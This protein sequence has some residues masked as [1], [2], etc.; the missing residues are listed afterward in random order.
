MRHSML[1]AAALAAVTLLPSCIFGC[2]AYSGDG[3]RAYQRGS[4]SM[5]ICTNGGFVANLASGGVEGRYTF[6]GTVTTATREAGALVAFRLT[7]FSDGTATAPELGP[8][9]WEKQNL[10]K[11][12]LDHADIQCADLETRPWWTAQ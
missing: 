9:A 3:D 10:D 7:D 8:L 11:T 12:D 2:G 4:E 6:D 1:V 5:I